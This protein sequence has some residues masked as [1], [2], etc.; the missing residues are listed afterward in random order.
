M[1]TS[2]IRSKKEPSVEAP[3]SDVSPLTIRNIKESLMGTEPRQKRQSVD[4]DMLHE[5]ISQNAMTKMRKM[6]KRFFIGEYDATAEEEQSLLN[7]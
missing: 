6:S 1:I 3:S 2:T 5:A 7:S 4:K